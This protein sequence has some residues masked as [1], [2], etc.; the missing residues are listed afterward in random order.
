METNSD[1]SLGMSA[2]DFYEAHRVDRNGVVS[3]GRRMADLTIPSIFP[4]AEYDTSHDSLAITNQ[5]VNSVLVSGLSN[6]LTLSALPPN[7]PICKFEPD[8]TAMAQDIQNDP[9]LYAVVEYGLSRK[10]E[11]H[12]KRLKSTSARTAYGKAT[13]LLLVSGNVL[14]LW[15][16]INSPKIYNLHTWVCV[17][18]AEGLP[19]VTV[20]QDEITM[21]AADK[22]VRE[23]VYKYR[24][25][26][27]QPKQ[28]GSAWQDKCYIYHVQQFMKDD[29]EWC[30]WQET[31]GGY[32]IP[33]TEYY[34]DFETPPMYAAGLITETGSHYALP[35]CH[36]FEGDLKAME[37]YSSS[38]QDGAAAVAWF[39][40]LVNPTGQTNIRDVRKA[41][42]LAILP[43]SAEDIT[44]YTS[45]KAGELSW[46]SSEAEKVAR[47]L[48]QAFASEASLQRSGERV[49]ATEWEALIRSL[50]KAMGGL[51]SAIAQSFQRWFVLRFI[52]LHTKE[53]KKLQKIPKGLVTISVSTG[54][55]GIGRNSEY[56]NLMGFATD[57]QAVLTPPIFAQEINPGAFL[58]RL[59][60]GRA[61]KVDGLVKTPEQKAQEQQAAT[62]QQQQQAL[63]EKGTGPAVQGGMDM[64]NQAVQQQQQPQQ[65]VTPNGGQ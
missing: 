52:H 11:I 54:L 34:S 41:D 22:D 64:L 6:S 56:E 50:D 33:G 7:L 58:S 61:V 42:N 45:G 31:E 46:V 24:I 9:E 13:D 48:G 51:Y 39:L 27:G 21:A 29:N 43:G 53:N 4:P 12:R 62:Q 10:E 59:A 47:R 20:L 57:A 18:D 2:Q 37:E 49:T 38:L 40:T 60:A 5:S 35:Y 36:M 32:V 63:L 19:L 26:K 65:G 55:D 14:C 16:N 1:T 25:E 30:Y 15:T 44:S 17:R 28:K 23:A 8:E 3:I